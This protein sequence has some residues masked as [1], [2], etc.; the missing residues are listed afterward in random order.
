MRGDHDRVAPLLARVLAVVDVAEYR[1]FAARTQHA[2]GLAALAPGNHVTAT[3]S[4]LTLRRRRQ[5]PASP[6]L[7]P[8]HRR[9]RR[10]RGA[11]RIPTRTPNASFSPGASRR[12]APTSATATFPGAARLQ[13]FRARSKKFRS[14]RRFPKRFIQSYRRGRSRAPRRSPRLLRIFSRARRLA[15]S[16]PHLLA[17]RRPARPRPHRRPW[18][19]DLA[20]QI[21]RRPGHPRPLLKSQRRNLPGDRRHAPGF[22]FSP[23]RRNARQLHLCPPGSNLGS[24]RSRSRPAGSRRRRRTRGRRPFEPRRHPRARPGRNE[25]HG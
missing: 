17:R 3:R 13:S 10:R 8:R 11:L 15:N 1:G 24:A 7:L 4:R 6:L 12:Q 23:R 20:R 22:R 2:A 9:P 21:W 16:W 5:T 18:L 19:S 14:R 25:R